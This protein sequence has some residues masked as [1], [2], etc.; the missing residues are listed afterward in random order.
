[1]RNGYTPI[2]IKKEDRAKYYKVLDIAHTTMNYKPF[3]QFVSELVVE[4]ER[5]WISLLD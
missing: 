2:I 1:M 4:S 3:I 5:L